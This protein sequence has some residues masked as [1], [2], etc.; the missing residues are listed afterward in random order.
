M[1]RVVLADDE[2][3]ILQALERR[4]QW[5]S[6][7][8][9]IVGTATHGTAALD[10]ILESSPDLLVTDIRMPGL[11]G[12]ELGRR[13]RDSHPD[14]EIILISGFSE[15]EY[16]QDGIELGVLG[17]LLKP[18]QQDQLEQ[19][20]KRTVEIL[21]RNRTQIEPEWFR[22]R[23]FVTRAQSSGKLYEHLV[24]EGVLN[25]GDSLFCVL[26]QLPQ[27]LDRVSDFPSAYYHRISPRLSAYFMSGTRQQCTEMRIAVTNLHRQRGIAAGI[28]SIVSDPQEVE[29]TI[30]E[31]ESAFV[32]AVFAGTEEAVLFK[33]GDPDLVPFVQD[34]IK[35]IEQGRHETVRS[36]L[37][38]IKARAGIPGAN[39]EALYF[40]HNSLVSQTRDY[41]TMTPATGLLP[42]PLGGIV[43][44]AFRYS[45]LSSLYDDLETMLA[46]LYKNDTG[47]GEK[48]RR[49]MIQ[50]REY[51]EHHFA[52][53]LSMDRL[54]DA[55]EIDKNQ[56]SQRF[57]NA[58]GKGISEFI[59]DIRIGHAK[60]LL[61]TTRMP[62]ATVGELCGYG[63]YYYFARVFKKETGFT[64][65]EYRDTQQR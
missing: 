10:L 48:P 8:L 2:P 58:H 4:V 32:R 14:I 59:K 41:Y 64:C 65:S 11:N 17:Y 16:A 34:A 61:T 15:F 55:F 57:K 43:D 26:T 33:R 53:D 36:L 7:G 5:S 31:A 56:L 19:L 9:E 37:K 30:V 6:L 60:F 46:Y 42:R 12:I 63:D 27:R 21:K 62:I 49:T 3:R 1:F 38:T 51:I 54:A 39:T 50:V 28:G 24:E 45:G 35:S 13:A 52:E 44:L 22:F 29:Q 25:A 18:I 23:S 40:L 47:T 20:L